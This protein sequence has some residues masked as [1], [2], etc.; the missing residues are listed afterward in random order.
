MGVSRRSIVAAPFLWLPART[1]FRQTNV[2]MFMTDDH[3]AWAM[4]AY[5]C[6]DMRTP[7]LD[8]LATEGA[9]FTRAYTCTPA[10]S[11]SRISYLT[12]EIPSQHGVQDSL[13]DED[14]FGPKARRFLDGHSTYSEILAKHGYKLGMCGKWHM[15][16]DTHA[17]RGFSY[18]H[19][20][21]GAGGSYRD[22]EFYTNGVRRK[23]FGFKTD[24]VA[25]GALEFLDRTRNSPFYLL[26]NFFSPREPY[27]FQPDR[28]RE[29]YRNCEFG[30]FPDEDSHPKQNPAFARLA[31]RRES[32]VAYSALVT[33]VDRN[34]GR[35]LRYLDRLKRRDETLIIFTS[36][37]GW[38]AGHHGVWGRGNGTIP[39]NLYEESVRVPMI[40]NL[41]GRIRAGHVVTPM[42]SNYDFFPTILDYLGYG[43]ARDPRLAGRSYADFLRGRALNWNNRIFFEYS[44]TRGIRTET[45]KY[46][47]R[48]KEWPSELYDLEADPGEAEN[49]IRDTRYAKTLAAMRADLAQFFHNR[50]APAIDDWRSS[51][52]QN[53]PVYLQRRAAK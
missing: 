12:G 47:E 10:S 19:T 9:R 44:Y 15:G 20:V 43:Q 29:P 22:P 24:L 42:V 27:D 32:K 17:Q 36:S 37:Q 16:D 3:G 25:D 7:V 53:L 39:F 50:S 52:H 45:M 14:S 11:P 31:G 8:Q 21:P 49:V 1:A 13:V 5:G 18:W 2:I 28:D 38:N 34:I 40:W 4:G 23:L 48:S 30:C 6:K 35:I 41:R 26:V 33:A 51:T 46:V